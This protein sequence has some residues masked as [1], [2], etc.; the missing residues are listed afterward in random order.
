MDASIRD[1]SA[2]GEGATDPGSRLEY[3]SPPM[4]SPRLLSTVLLLS[5]SLLAMC[6]AGCGRTNEFVPPPPPKVTVDTPE[7]RDVTTYMKFTG[8]T[9]ALDT[10]EIR[11]RVTGFLKTVEFEEGTRVK[12]GDLLYVIEQEPFIASL[13]AAEANQRSSIAERDLQEA[14]LSRIKD[15]ADKGA[16]SAVEILEAQA[17]YDGAVATAD[18]AKADLDKA[19]LDLG[20]T[21]IHAPIGGRLSRN[22][23]SEGNLVGAGDTLLTTVIELEPIKV[24]FE[25]NERDLIRLIKKERD[26]GKEKADPMTA[27]LELTDESRY[28]EEGEI[29]FVN[30]IVD[31][32][33]GTMEIRAEFP[34]A[35]HVLVPGLFVR[36]LLPV[37][38]NSAIL[39]PEIAL[40][41]DVVGS[42]LLV[43]DDKSIV[44]R[45]NVELG[46]EDG[47]QRVITSG[48]S[49][50]DRVI[51][52]GLQRAQP[53]NP[54]QAVESDS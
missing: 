14:L 53:G 47:N 46:Q 6:P 52:N 26:E 8:R 20:Y 16:A 19:T 49:P 22:L 10:V 25:I 33:T 45:R 42:Y 23:V 15:A 21:K 18:L 2:H 40:Q 34:N 35:R 44:Q 32:Q 28:E 41:R 5:A 24:Y 43:V 37:E 4:S 7:V 1:R 12:K 31:P 39:V 51:V 36:V 11:S 29:D 48:L 50:D 13:N 17:R 38:T 9:A 54:V 3:D 27:L 30:N